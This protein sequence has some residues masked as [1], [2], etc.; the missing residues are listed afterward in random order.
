M[1][2]VALA[3]SWP[4]FY[5]VR[6]HREAFTA[7]PAVPLR[8]SRERQQVSLLCNR[9]DDLNKLS[10]LGEDSPSLDTVTSCRVR[11]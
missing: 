6:D 10:D 2:S 1:S 7:S 5:F 8:W 11:L 4:F 3:V 9:G